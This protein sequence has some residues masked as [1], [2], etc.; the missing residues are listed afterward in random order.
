MPNNVILSGTVSV[1]DFLKLRE[2]MSSPEV[3]MSVSALVRF[4][5]LFLLSLGK[6]NIAQLKKME[7]KKRACVVSDAIAKENEWM[8]FQI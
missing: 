7:A 6:E 1:E 4:A 2:I 5:V 3:D 8:N